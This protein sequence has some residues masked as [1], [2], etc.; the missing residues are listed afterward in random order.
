[1][2]AGRSWSRPWGIN[3]GRV[4]SGHLESWSAGRSRSALHVFRGTTP[5]TA[6]AD[7]LVSTGD[8]I[9]NNRTVYAGIQMINVLKLNI[10]QTRQELDSATVALQRRV[11]AEL[12][13]AR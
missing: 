4:A 3:R 12:A 13:R 2:S 8:E 10:R 5:L 9:L 1:M 6:T 11:D 7:A